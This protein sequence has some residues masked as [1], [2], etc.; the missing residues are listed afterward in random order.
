[1]TKRSKKIEHLM[2]ADESTCLV[3]HPQSVCGIVKKVTAMNGLYTRDVYAT[4]LDNLQEECDGVGLTSDGLHRLVTLHTFGY[5]WTRGVRYAA[6]E[7][8]SYFQGTIGI[9]S[10]VVLIAHS[11]GGLVCR[12]LLEE[13]CHNGRTTTDTT[14]DRLYRKVKMLYAIGVPH[15]GTVRALH[16]LIDPRGGNF[17]ESC[18]NI[19]S[20]FDMI[21]FSD[22]NAQIDGIEQ[23]VRRPCSSTL[24][25]RRY[26]SE[27]FLKK[28][29]RDVVVDRNDWKPKN[30]F[31]SRWHFDKNTRERIISDYI[32]C[33]IDRL[34][35]RFPLLGENRGRLLEAAN[36]HFSL[37]SSHRPF[38]CVYLFVNA[39]GFMSPSLIDKDNFMYRK[40][41]YGDG[42]VCS[43]VEESQQ[44][45]ESNLLGVT[46]R[47]TES[48]DD[49]YE[50]NCSVH[51]SMLQH[52][53]VFRAV[54]EVLARDIFGSATIGKQN[55]IKY[56]WRQ[57]VLNNDQTEIVSFSS[58]KFG[59]WKIT[60][61]NLRS[62]RCV[63]NIRA[64]DFL[65]DRLTSGNNGGLRIDMI[66]TTTT[67][68]TPI[69]ARRYGTSPT[70][71][72]RTNNVT[73][74]SVTPEEVWS[75]VTVIVSGQYKILEVG[76][77]QSEHH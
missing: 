37:N 59:R 63:L 40:C 52:I 34:T 69:T 42:L 41:A 55:A 17:T 46:D 7:L 65:E 33:L 38:G 73:R 39:V 54:R 62:D 1:M 56:L 36:V 61:T 35:Y 13:I 15:Y 28:T 30:D 21:P 57:S 29:N 24:P 10:A 68:Y 22:L 2:N 26:R 48:Y 66:R 75:R 47:T 14:A 18:R 64:I 23:G 58:I 74:V 49:S 31:G 71:D 43:L 8:F 19:Q 16:F 25:L 6:E 51:V 4:F 67:S 11:M 50:R 70:D 9:Y 3:T 12:Y 72:P 60:A 76:E 32:S 77:L 45:D 53:D 20:L 5:D 44:N 27:L